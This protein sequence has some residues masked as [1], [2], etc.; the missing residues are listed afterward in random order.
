MTAS[1]WKS[2]PCSKLNICL[3]TVLLSGQ[4]FRWKKN[5]QGEWLGVLS[6]M[7]W[8]VKQTDD[9]ILF[10]VYG[11]KKDVSTCADT[12]KA[13]DNLYL[14][15]IDYGRNEKQQSE[16]I[17]S[18][19]KTACSSS[20]SNVKL[21]ETL[22]KVENKAEENLDKTCGKEISKT[23]KDLRK[24][25]GVVK[26]NSKSKNKK[27]DAFL[28]KGLLQGSTC[29]HSIEDGLGSLESQPRV[30]M[31]SLTDDTCMWQS[32]LL[33][34]YF[35][36]NVN[37]EELYQQWSSKDPHFH[38]VALNFYGIRILRQ[39]PVENLISFVCSSNNNISRISSMVEKLCSNYGTFI[40]RVD[41][42]DYYTFPGFSD[43]CE[44]DVEA[45]LRKLGFGYRAKFIANIAKQI[46]LEKGEH[47]L[48]SLREK[49][50]TDAKAELMTLP[51]VGAK[52][53]DCVCLMSLDK[54]E[55]LPVDTHVWQITMRHYMAKL[56]TTKSLT[57]KLYNEIG[58]FYRELWGPYAGW[59]HSVLFTADLRHNKDRGSVDG[60]T[61]LDSK[62]RSIKS[63]DLKEKTLKKSK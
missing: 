50:Y 38:Q 37:L 35:Q 60:Q 49:S 19:Q 29:N 23:V 54:P 57:P 17:F 58:D 62:K 31:D 43:L 45:K 20:S 3:D 11:E 48:K 53:A 12:D 63:Q 33:E 47:W 14:K 13:K 27:S 24:H 28:R 51:G 42:I 2:F 22:T 4:S 25:C 39:D 55:A 15:Q 21:V 52:V 59:A 56:Q 46:T 26:K 18:Q 44:N 5:N 9:R 8:R 41:E 7:V 61:K 36:L 6:N 16:F 30:L 1:C 40:A 32:H 10:Q 34:D